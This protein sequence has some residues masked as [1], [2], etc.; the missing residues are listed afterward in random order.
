MST[1][2]LHGAICQV[3]KGSGVSD[4]NLVRIDFEPVGTIHSSKYTENASSSAIGEE[5][6]P[7]VHYDQDWALINL[8]S[9]LFH[10]NNTF[11]IPGTSGETTVKG[12]IR[13]EEMHHGNVHVVSAITGVCEGYLSSN[14]TYWTFEQSIFEV[15]MILLDKELSTIPFSFLR[16]GS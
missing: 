16:Y 9:P 4:S 1:F 3:F 15:R 14:S 12:Y 10:S 13:N 7:N 2:F 5:T 11:R 6:T 8:Q